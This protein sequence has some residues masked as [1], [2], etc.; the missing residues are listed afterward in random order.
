MIHMSHLKHASVF[1]DH[2][3]K[4]EGRCAS[5]VHQENINQTVVVFSVKVVRLIPFL[6]RVVHNEPIANVTPVTLDLQDRHAHCALLERTRKMSVP[7][8]VTYVRITRYHSSAPYYVQIALVNLDGWVRMQGLVPR[9][10]QENIKTNS[11]ALYV[12]LENTSR[13]LQHQVVKPVRLI[14][15]HSRIV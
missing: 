12:L 2:T 13:N 6:R 7:L 3:A 11:Y 15:F 14:R 8:N 1:Q 5:Y 4:V 10:R 9:V